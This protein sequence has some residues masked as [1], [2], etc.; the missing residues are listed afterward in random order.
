MSKGG[1][2]KVHIQNKDTF[3]RNIELFKD[4]QGYLDNPTQ[5][6]QR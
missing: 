4:I 2:K 5:K 3:N 1:D 6:R